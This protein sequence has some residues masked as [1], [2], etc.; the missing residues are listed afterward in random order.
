MRKLKRI[1]ALLLVFCMMVGLV[2]TNAIPVEAADTRTIVIAGS[3]YQ[4]SGT[5]PKSNTSSIL[6]QIKK[7]YSTV[8]GF[9]FG[10]DYTQSP[11]SSSAT[12][13][14][15]EELDA[16][17]GE[18]YP[19]MTDRI[20]VQGNHDPD[21]VI[22]NSILATSGAHDAENY[23]VYVIN[24]KDYPCGYNTSNLQSVT[25]ATAESLDSYLDSKVNEGYK[26]PVFVVSHLPLHYTSR[27]SSQGDGMY[28]KYIYDVLDEAGAKGLNIIF[29]FGHNHS[30][31][32]DAYLGNG[33]V[34]LAEGKTITVAN[35]GNCD[36]YFTDTLTFTYMN[37]GYVGYIGG[38]SDTTL[39]MTTFEITDDQVA[40]K[41]YD[42]DGLHN[43]KA[44]GVTSSGNP[45]ADTTV[46]GTEGATIALTTP[47]SD[48]TEGG[49]DEVTPDNSGETE[50]VDTSGG[51]W[52]TISD[53][54]GKVIYELDTD[55]VDIGKEYL[56][57]A[58]KYTK[59]LSAAA[60]SRNAID[61]EINGNY[62]YVEA[63]TYGWTFISS[64]SKYQ[65]QNNGTYLGSSNS[66]LTS[67]NAS[68]TWDVSNNGDGS[69]EITTSASWS[70]YHLR[71]SDSN[72]IFQVSRN[73]TNPVRLYKYV[74]TESSEKL[75]AKL[76]GLLKYTVARGATAEEALVAVKAGIDVKTATQSDYSN[77]QD[78][79]DDAEGLTW[80]LAS[81]YDGTI[82]GEYAVTIAYNGI[83]LDVAKVIVPEV[84][85]TDYSVEPEVGAVN[86][87]A[88]K[89][90]E[91]GA[92]IIVYL[93]DDTSYRVPVTLSMLTDSEGKAIS[94]KEIGTYSNL[95]L[96]YNGEV[97]TKNFTLT[98]QPKVGNNYPEYPAEG[99]VKVNK[100]GTGIDF[101]ASGIAQVELSASGIPMNQ[102][103]DVVI[104]LDTSSSM[105]SK[106]G[107]LN[108]GTRIAV[109]R[110]A[111]DNLIQQ[112]Q[113][114]R[115]DGSN[116]DIDIA[117]ASFNANTM[118]SGSNFIS[119]DNRTDPAYTQTAKY[120][121]L[122]DKEGDGWLDIMELA[123]D[124]GTA[125]NGANI[126]TGSGTNYDYGLQMAYD[127]L[128][129]KQADNTTE[130]EQFVIFMS[131]G[132][133]YQYNGVY[134]NGSVKSWVN[135]ILG[136][137]KTENDIPNTVSDKNKKFYYGYAGGKGQRHRI[138]EAIKGDPDETFDIVSF[139]K[140]TS[141]E[142]IS[143]PG[144]GATMYSIGLL[145][146]D[147]S[148]SVTADNQATV[149]RNIAS[150]EDL[151]KNITTADGLNG[152]FT[153]FAN[154]VLMSA[155]NARFVD[156]MGSDYDLQLATVNY[157]PK[158]ST[159]KTETITPVIEVKSYDIY[160]RQDYLNGYIKEN[161][162][163]DRKGTY[164]LTEVV[165]F[166][167]DG[168]KA[169][170]NLIDEDNDGKYGVT[171]N[172]EGTYTITD[173]D[174]NILTD[175]VIYAKSFTYN[176]GSDSVTIEENGVTVEAES[177]YW[178]LGTITTT[179][180]ALS[181]YVYLTDSFGK[182]KDA[183]S[184]P[185]N[186]YATL[187][188]DNYLGNPCQKDT[189][190]PVLAWEAANV[191]YA[192][193]LVNTSGQPVNMNGEVVPFANRVTIVN[194]TLYQ[195]VL[196]NVKEGETIEPLE[197][198]STGV[199]PDGYF[200]YDE[201][202]KYTV[203]I[204]SNATGSWTIDNGQNVATTYV[205]DFS[206]KTAYSNELYTNNTTHAYDYTHTT[207]WFA[208]KWEPDTIDDTVVVDYGLPVDVHVMTNDM[209][210]SYGT[211][212]GVGKGEVTN[213]D[214]NNSTNE[215]ATVT[216][217]GE[218]GNAEVVVPATGANESNSVIRYTQS[219]MQMSGYETFTYSVQ[220]ANSKYA[221]NNG[222]YYGKLTVIPATTI[223]YEDD[224]VEFSSYTWD[225]TKN[226]WTE[227]ESSLWTQATDKTYVDNTIITQ[228]E[229]RPGNVNYA[230]DTV[231]D[232]NNVYGY[233]SAYN[234]YSAYSLGSAMMTTV[235]FDNYALAEFSFYGTG[236]DVISL[237]S[238][239]T[240][241][242]LVYVYDANGTKVR[243]NIV[244]TYYGYVFETKDM[245]GNET[246]DAGEGEWITSEN[247]PNALYQVPVMEV[248]G[249]EYGKYRVEIKAMYDP[250]YDHVNPAETGG[251]YDFYLDA[252]RIYDPANDGA[253]DD[254]VIEDAYIN[255]NEG[256]PVYEEL[257]NN[258]IES[259]VLNSETNESEISGIAFIDSSDETT[260]VAD[261]T[262]YGPNNEL[263]L[264][265]GQAIVFNLNLDE[266][267]GIVNTVQLGIK[268]AN[269]DEVNYKLFDG[270]LVGNGEDL[271]NIPPTTIST[272]T[273]MYYD[274]TSLKDKTILIYNSGSEGM[275][276]LTDIKVTFTKNPGAVENLF[277]VLASQIETIVDN[278]NKER[279]TTFI[280][281]LI[282][283]RT[284]PNTV[285]VGNTI[286]VTVTTSVDVAAISVNDELITSYSVDTDGNKVWTA[287]VTTDTKGEKNIEVVAY[288]AD[289]LTSEAKSR[290]VTVKNISDWINTTV[291]KILKNLRGWLIK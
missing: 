117:I 192:F 257:R 101:Q 63:D 291:D 16:V 131:D 273:G 33:S 177:F 229:D 58:E 3:D 42:A 67:G 110:P 47:V 34:Y 74:R 209:F 83:I 120:G 102:G 231:I 219:D 214:G 182:G 217:N 175:N 243:S 290:T 215:V 142:L 50:T 166:S 223:Y 183:G 1:L 198:L 242:I 264:A 82:P 236:F 13:T 194:P 285:Y 114:K 203:K 10:G 162:I 109:L 221:Q 241:T 288:N 32:Y 75:Y 167:A 52:V 78:I 97:I 222:Y 129:K 88:S 190:S 28:A 45:T 169:Y 95:T 122:T 224:F 137:Y 68:N 252:I 188:Y 105:T 247:N 138:A 170:S 60:N 56:I 61:I 92:E 208:V 103:V 118:K 107:A 180:L 81:D 154:D 287:K 144:L 46:V 238:N 5:N 181:Y 123:P 200:L 43:L 158:G 94:T 173:T 233:D 218:Y 189:I 191:S 7:D 143:V 49:G 239:Q 286:T 113:T 161:K 197:V 116:P 112:L 235:D 155:Y 179:E 70:T 220:Y 216:A 232:A 207:V 250:N 29:L 199:L 53:G 24:E 99:A 205:T 267:E 283:I 172:E 280:P 40:V 21:E 2:P 69:Y 160:T 80:T 146:A 259:A 36:S 141:G 184:Y 27:T 159:E 148:N 132:A 126:P 150:S 57:V 276:S 152:A 244:D 204:N 213:T 65:I 157:A 206:S 91:T 234:K 249:L 9:L 125:N 195:E 72:S 262:N 185:T 281:N 227:K 93:K 79:T 35:E 90:A 115:E 39:T 211:L 187:Y 11:D 130:R 278:M 71:W 271:A 48:G 20:Y 201:S 258:V 44:A 96:T 6:T 196:L 77:E 151:F 38:S 284:T 174:D 256:W 111:V 30:N 147:E 104:I 251:V 31:G 156:K 19:D 226:E 202:A 272:A 265:P 145:L 119:D 25:K 245:D 171:V 54:S 254:T 261:Y 86:K 76:D 121:L 59:A 134:S 139:D 23:G 100:T 266:Y 84:P 193:Y 263:Y 66:G 279:V 98:V 165:K 275:L 8:D 22:T 282:E 228:D 89:L 274:I 87:G 108:Y 260:S 168:T 269:G 270:S 149:L 127:L 85:I 248:S 212:V 106:I 135:W 128:A 178:N 163:G 51:N 289:G 176:N 41:R 15:K 253:S 37:Y 17:I 73:N 268:S 12:E 136:N 210:G 140:D 18:F 62:A 277:N 14:G 246:I 4:Q 153:Q 230:F 124:W 237:T 164:T 255:D 55:G 26:K 240:G 186:E 64:G 225:Y 133:P